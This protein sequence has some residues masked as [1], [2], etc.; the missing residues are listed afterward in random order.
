MRKRR[1]LPTIAAGQL[2][3]RA[4]GQFL[5]H[6]LPSPTTSVAE[7]LVIKD[8]IQ[9]T[10]EISVGA[11][12]APAR[13]SA[14]KG[15]LHEIIGANTVATQQCKR[16]AAQSR[17]VS[18]DKRGLVWHCISQRRAAAEQPQQCSQRSSAAAKTRVRQTS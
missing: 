6:A 17:N 7:K 13:E 10:A 1:L 18:L 12:P 2:G 5:V 9:P 14:F 15:V 3:L 16:K 11:A 4:S 8:R